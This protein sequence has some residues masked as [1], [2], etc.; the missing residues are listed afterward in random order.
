VK[1]V[2]GGHAGPVELPWLIVDPSLTQLEIDLLRA[3]ERADNLAD[4]LIVSEMARPFR[5]RWEYYIGF[6]P[7]QPQSVLDRLG[8]GGAA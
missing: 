8:D 1:A 5:E 3:L 2:D 6:P 7:E 4:R